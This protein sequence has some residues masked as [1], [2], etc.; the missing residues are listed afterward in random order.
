MGEGDE[1]IKYIDIDIIDDG[2][3]ESDEF[4]VLELTNPSDGVYI[5]DAN[6]AHIKILGETVEV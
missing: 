3:E 2:N 1:S 5:G 4:I 6:T